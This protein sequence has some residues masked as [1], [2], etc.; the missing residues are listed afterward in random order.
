MQAPISNVHPPIKA[1]SDTNCH[2]ALHALSS[3][4]PSCTETIKAKAGDV[5][6]QP[7]YAAY[8]CSGKEKKSTTM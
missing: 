6:M 8:A 3:S 1:T 4:T 5:H 7:A 2:L